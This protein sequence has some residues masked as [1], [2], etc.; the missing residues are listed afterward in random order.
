MRCCPTAVPLMAVAQDAATIDDGV[1]D[2]LP[3]WNMSGEVS[4][5]RR[6]ESFYPPKGTEAPGAMPGASFRKGMS[7]GAAVSLLNRPVLAALQTESPPACAE[8]LVVVFED[9]LP[10]L[11]LAPVVIDLD[12][13]VTVAQRI[14]T[15]VERRHR[16]H[17]P[18][19]RA[20]GVGSVRQPK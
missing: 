3:P 6:L 8:H 18:T 14:D 7:C 16:P 4:N 11:A 2:V 1:V 9:L 17:A 5:Q 19:Y 12:G 15:R 10:A 20:P 13:I